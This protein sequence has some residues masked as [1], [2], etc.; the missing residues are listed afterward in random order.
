MLW[1]GCAEQQRASWAEQGAAT[2]LNC[3]L[4]TN[5]RTLVDGPTNPHCATAV[6]YPY[7]VP[8]CRYCYDRGFLQCL[9]ECGGMLAAPAIAGG[10]IHKTMA[11]VAPKLVSVSSGVCCCH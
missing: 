4:K 7:P 11:F 8:P 2:L 3:L 1:L 10:A 9:W 6:I 5:V